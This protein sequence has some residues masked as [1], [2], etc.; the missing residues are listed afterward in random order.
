MAPVGAARASRWQVALS[1]RVPCPRTSGRL[2]QPFAFPTIQWSLQAAHVPSP[3]AMLRTLTLLSATAAIVLAMAADDTCPCPS[4]AGVSVDVA[5]VDEAG[6]QDQVDDAL[7]PCHRAAAANDE[8]EP[9]GTATGDDAHRAGDLPPDGRAVHA[10]GHAEL[11]CPCEHD[12]DNP[13]CCCPGCP[14]AQGEPLDLDPFGLKAALPQR[15]EVR[16]HLQAQPSPAAGPRAPD[17]SRQ[18]GPTVP[19]A[20]RPPPPPPDTHTDL[21]VQ[22]QVFRI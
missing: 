18:Y 1:W 2:R 13:T 12:D 20:I 11:P 3:S 6:V 22:H 19:L 17:I 14:A 7:P 5:T 15:H 8:A 16:G 9:R 4:M 21:T 10:H